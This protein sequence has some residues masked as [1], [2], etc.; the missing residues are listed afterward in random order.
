M[1]HTGFGVQEFAIDCNSKDALNIATFLFRDLPGAESG[2]DVMVYDLILSGAQP[3][4]SLSAGEKSLYYGES[5]YQLAYILMNEVIYHCINSD[6]SNIALHAGAVCNGNRGLLLPGKS[7]KGKSTLTGWLVLNG[8]QYL[9][10]ELIFLRN[11]GVILP[12]TRPIN[13]KVTPGHESWLLADASES[14][15]ICGDSA[16]M[17]SHRKLNPD[18]SPVSPRLTDIIF[19]EY[20]AGS[21]LVFEEIS[22]AKSCLYL[23]QSHVNARNLDGHGVAELSAI[24]RHCRSYKL[25]YS[26]F[27]DLEAVFEDFR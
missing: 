21:R 23:L 13:L 15:I 16:A 22:P 20:K 7:G 19:P 4:F 10:D 17:I 12:F 26:R 14:D 18:Y 3:I 1:Y 24:I 11:D 27:A 25:T 5:R 2:G 9:T 8:F 6:E